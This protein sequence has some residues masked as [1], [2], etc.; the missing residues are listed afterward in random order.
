MI[1]MK[2]LF[3]LFL[4]L[5]AG[6][7]FSYYAEV[8]F[9][10]QDNGSVVISGDSDHP[11]LQ[12]G[13]Y[14]TLTSKN[15]GLWYFNFDSNDLFSSYVFELK[16]P[17]NS[18]INYITISGF[19]KIK[20]D[21]T[22]VISGFGENAKMDLKAQYSF[23]AARDTYYWLLVVALLIFMVGFAGYAAW[24][25]FRR[26]VNVASSVQ[27]QLEP[28]KTVLEVILTDREK[29]ILELI[30]NNNGKVTQNKIQQELNLPK[31]SLSRNLLSLEKKGLIKKVS[32]GLSNI[33][34]LQE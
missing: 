31:S 28:K 26:F 25:H 20:Q 2:K 18:E 27:S 33:V 29:Q 24:T 7:S 11:L 12:P 34:V 8:V 15:N 21:N 23:S 19:K 32:K 3:L 22:I 13:T 5:L 4:I 1:I 16:F 14:E 17:E 9:E 6:L 30:K 10:I